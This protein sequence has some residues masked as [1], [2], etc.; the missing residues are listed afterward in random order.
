MKP[1]VAT[2]ERGQRVSFYGCL[3]RNRRAVWHV[4][5]DGRRL[6]PFYGLADRAEAEKLA[7]EAL[8]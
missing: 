5:V 2:G 3:D 6:T 7:D 1:G 8:R 4:K